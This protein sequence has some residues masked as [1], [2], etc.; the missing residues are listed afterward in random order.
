MHSNLYLPS[1]LHFDFRPQQ[2]ESIRRNLEE[3]GR[4]TTP[5]CKM[6]YVRSDDKI[7]THVRNTVAI[8]SQ[9]YVAPLEHI[10]GEHEH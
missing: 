10:E 1:K 7:C 5:C 4:T 9:G 8:C 6:H 2:A 3:H